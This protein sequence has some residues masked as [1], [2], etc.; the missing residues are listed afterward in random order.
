MVLSLLRIPMTMIARYTSGTANL[1]DMAAL[2][3]CDQG[4]VGVGVVSGSAG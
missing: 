1:Y 4:V 2:L 3:S